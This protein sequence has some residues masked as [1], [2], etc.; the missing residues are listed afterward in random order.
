MQFLS[1]VA[2]N[3]TDHVDVEGIVRDLG[4]ILKPS[5]ILP[6]GIHGRL[7]M[8]IDGWEMH[9][10]RQDS[11]LRRRY[12]MAHMIGHW[13]MHQDLL[14][15]GLCEGEDYSQD[16][17]DDY[18]NEEIGRAE[19]ENANVFAS[20]LLLPAGLV[21][22]LAEKANMS[23]GEAAKRLRCSVSGLQIRMEVFERGAP[24][25]VLE[26]MVPLTASI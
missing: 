26:Q 2:R 8:D 15:M 1:I 21:L 22:P 14:G 12:T 4:I 24:T 19:E 5:E 20:E 16:P 18:A 10:N 13:V 11:D 3:T 9:L 23:L 25:N 17:L 6:I 7:V